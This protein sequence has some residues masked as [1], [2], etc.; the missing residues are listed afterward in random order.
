MCKKALILSLAVNT[1]GY[2]SNNWKMLSQQD[3]EA[4]KP[5]KIRAGSKYENPTLERELD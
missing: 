4:W 2:V 1:E 5:G 3:D